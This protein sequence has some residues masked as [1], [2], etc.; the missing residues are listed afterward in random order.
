MT[1][2][3]VSITRKIET[4]LRKNGKPYKHHSRVSTPKKR[5]A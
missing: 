1:R 2:D 5:G 3:K 4:R